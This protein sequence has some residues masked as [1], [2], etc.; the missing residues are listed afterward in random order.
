[1]PAARPFVTEE[2]LLEYEKTLKTKY[3]E[4]I[5]ADFLVA[6]NQLPNVL[7]SKVY[8]RWDLVA[9]PE[10]NKFI[11][12]YIASDAEFLISHDKH[13]SVLRSIK[14][15]TVNIVNIEEFKDSIA[16]DEGWIAL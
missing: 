12:C 1:M 9:D 3:S 10:S 2:I 4:D 14:F 7:N 6:L 8:Y 5:A 11:D 15:P 16:A 13:F